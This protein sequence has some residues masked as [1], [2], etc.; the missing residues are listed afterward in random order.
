MYEKGLDLIRRAP[1]R[2]LT[3]V[4]VAALSALRCNPELPSNLDI[5]FSE[6]FV[7]PSAAGFKALAAAGIDRALADSLVRGVRYQ[8]RPG[9]RRIFLRDKDN[10]E[11]GI[12]V[13]SPPVFDS[14]KRYPLIIYLHGGLGAQRNDKGVRAWQMLAPLT[15]SM[16]LFLASPSANRDA[17]W[18]SDAGLSRMLQTLRYMSLHYPIDSSRVFLAGVSDGATG[19]YAAA[20]TICAPFAG[21][22]AISGFAGLL[23]AIGME[24][25][26]RNL[27]QRP[28]YNVNAGNDRLYPLDRVNTVL[29]HLER[30][31]V[32]IIRKEYPDEE[33]GFAYREQ[34]FDA[35]LSYLRSWQRPHTTSLSWTPVNGVKNLAANILSYHA[36]N[37]QAAISGF[38]QND[39]LRLV[40]RNIASLRI[41]APQSAP[42][43]D[44]TVLLQRKTLSHTKTP[45]RSSLY[46]ELLQ[47]YCFPSVAA[48]NVYELTKLSG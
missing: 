34:E 30:A 47:H 19:C 22:F 40:H 46:L 35:L 42:D 2:F 14:V 16:R 24:L 45:M 12:G 43:E 3:L 17:A 37:G 1:A 31:G 36:D 38:W 44:I 6:W 11:Y 8:S 48:R 10:T 21:F 28:I 32:R 27:M 26:P 7:S 9:E 20:N 39:T 13:V 15:D 25:Q 18:W 5:A 41:I 4:C 23:P 29:D 33:H